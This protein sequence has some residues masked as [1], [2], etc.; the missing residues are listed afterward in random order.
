MVTGGERGAID[1]VVARNG[2]MGGAADWNVTNV[3][4]W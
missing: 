3:R 4:R 2:R 1:I